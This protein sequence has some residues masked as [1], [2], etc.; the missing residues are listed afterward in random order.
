MLYL[1][2]YR[3]KKYRVIHWKLTNLLFWAVQQNQK[4]TIYCNHLTNRNNSFLHFSI[5]SKTILNCKISILTGKARITQLLSHN[6]N[7]GPKQHKM[8]KSRQDKINLNILGKPNLTV[9][10]NCKTQQKTVKLD[11]DIIRVIFLGNKTW[12]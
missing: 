3:L 2:L 12:E 9:T 5:V 10:N 11:Y 6:L 1:N 8:N 7:F 4:N